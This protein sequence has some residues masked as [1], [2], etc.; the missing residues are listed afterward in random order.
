MIQHLLDTQ[1]DVIESSIGALGA[2]GPT[3]PPHQVNEIIDPLLA[4]FAKISDE[5]EHTSTM[6]NVSRIY[7]D[8][9]H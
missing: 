4:Q 2:F 3:R 7:Q 1:K 8:G 9:Q 6:V 5:A